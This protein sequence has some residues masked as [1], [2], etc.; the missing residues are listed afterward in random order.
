MR[1]IAETPEVAAWWGPVADDF[2]L[3]DEP[4]ATRFVIVVD[5]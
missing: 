2:P 5:G 1:A 3:A 4:D